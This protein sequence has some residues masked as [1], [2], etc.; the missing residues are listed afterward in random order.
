MKGE[1]MNSIEPK[2]QK[3]NRDYW[4]KDCQV[5]F[6]GGYGYG[7]H[8][9]EIA[10]KDG[11]RRWEAKTINVGK[12]EEV[13]VVLNGGLIPDTF[14]LAQ[15]EVLTNI[16]NRKEGKHGRAEAAVRTPRV[17]RR[18]P[19]GSL[20]NSLS[21]WRCPGLAKEAYRKGL[22]HPQKGSGCPHRDGFLLG[23][24]IASST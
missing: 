20:S 9:V 17:L 18:S 3:R 10:G 23:I 16:V 5:F 1:S 4:S 12:E 2:E 6:T 24:H 14:T 15:R 11:L 22:K 21:F 13:L 8:L 19:S 7:I